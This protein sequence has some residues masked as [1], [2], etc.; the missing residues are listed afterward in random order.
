MPHLPKTFRP[1]QHVP[2]DKRRGTST[3]RGYGYR[4][5]K[6]RAHYLREHPLCVECMRLGHTV[7]ASVVDHIKPHRGDEALFNDESNWQSLCTMHHNIKTAK[8]L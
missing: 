7:P 2:A 5:Q 6:Q 4:W 1:S 8:G 3:Q